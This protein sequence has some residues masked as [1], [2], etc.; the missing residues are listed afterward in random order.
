MAL[1]THRPLRPE[2][3][4]GITKGA[5]LV[6]HYHS[7]NK[8]EISVLFDRIEDGRLHGRYGYLG[9]P[10]DEEM[11][12]YLYEAGGLLCYGS[13]AEPLWAAEP[14]WRG[15]TPDEFEDEGDD[16]EYRW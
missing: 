16:D 6:L 2:D 10:F 13:G 4:E 1:P 11:G 5:L 8:G 14:Q 3:F 12:D 15:A 7:T 9:E